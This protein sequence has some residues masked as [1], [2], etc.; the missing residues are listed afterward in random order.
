MMKL[1]TQTG[2]LMNHIYS[3]VTNPQPEV[4]MG[5]T[6][7]MWSDR[8]AG[9]IVAI[10][11]DILVVA[12]DDVKRIDSN[13]ISESQE[14]KYTTNPNNRKTYWKKDKSGKYCEYYMNRDTNRYN[15]CGTGCHLG[16]GY[17]QE[18][19]DFSF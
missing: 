5:V 1:G 4:G 8:H 18:Y 10:E 3:R 19:Y 7:C 11:K 13:G 12:D 14:Y 6:I 2:S 16:I 9:T 17:R 15:K